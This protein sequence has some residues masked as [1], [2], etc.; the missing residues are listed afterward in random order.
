[1]Q[2]DRHLER[3]RIAVPIDELVDRSEG[4][5]GRDL[6]N[7]ADALPQIALSLDREQADQTVVDQAFRRV[8]PPTEGRGIFR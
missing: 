1:L 4:M 7:F 3:D 5:S 8:L 6:K 2:D